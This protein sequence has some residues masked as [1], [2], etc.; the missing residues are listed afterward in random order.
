[1]AH[2]IGG[3]D[4]GVC[5][6]ACGKGGGEGA[7]FVG[8][9]GGVGGGFSV[10]SV[11]FLGGRGVLVGGT[12]ENCGERGGETANLTGVVGGN[13]GGIGG[14]FLIFLIGFLIYRVLIYL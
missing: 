1:M 4:G 2:K 11:Y 13:Y 8:I 7:D 12:G 9:T 6:N 14:D 10:F 3:G 5:K